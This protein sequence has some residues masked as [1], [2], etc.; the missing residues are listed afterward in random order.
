MI[1]RRNKTDW[2]MTITGIDIVA[3]VVANPRDAQKW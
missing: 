3:L 2:L 1:T